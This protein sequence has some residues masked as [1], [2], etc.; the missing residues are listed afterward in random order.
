[1]GLTNGTAYDVYMAH[2]DEFSNVVTDS[3]LNNSPSGVSAVGFDPAHTTML[4]TGDS[5]TARTGSNRLLV[6]NV[7]FRTDTAGGFGGG[8]TLTLGSTDFT[9]AQGK[10]IRYE[11]GAGQFYLKDTDIPAGANSFSVTTGDGLVFEDIKIEV[12]EMTGV[13]QTTPISLGTAASE[14][15]TPT[16]FSTT[17]MTTADNSVVVSIAAFDAPAA[18]SALTGATSLTDD[19]SGLYIRHMSGYQEVA[20]SG[21][22]WSHDHSNTSANPYAYSSIE[23]IAA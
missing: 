5:F 6:A 22:A 3:D 18:T 14:K 10:N 1:M 13:N 20:T 15:N 4:T 19:T 8:F 11:C 23:V 2:A 17:G 7:T 12:L 21:T 16:S 9:L